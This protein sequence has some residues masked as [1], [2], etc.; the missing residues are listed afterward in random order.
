MVEID[1]VFFLFVCCLA[2]YLFIVGG[3]GIAA[4]AHKLWS[5]RSFKAILPFRIL[6]AVA[7]TI[8]LQV[9]RRESGTRESQGFNVNIFRSLFIWLFFKRMTSTSG[10]GITGSITNLATRT[11]ILTIPGA[12]SFSLTSAGSCARNIPK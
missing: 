3:F 11:P 4:G 8:A 1:L 5:H 7:Q 12:D 10:V 2:Y 6:I 9:S